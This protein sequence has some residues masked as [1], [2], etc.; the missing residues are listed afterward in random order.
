MVFIAGHFT[1]QSVPKS[2][3]LL[4]VFTDNI[5]SKNWDLYNIII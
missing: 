5:S 4:Y 2:Q 3:F 1:Y